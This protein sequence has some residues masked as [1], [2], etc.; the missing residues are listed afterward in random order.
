MDPLSD[1]I[2]ASVAEQTADSVLVTDRDGVIEYV[3]PSFE[4]LTGYAKNE[5]VGQ[6]PSLLK[7]GLHDQEFYGLLW[8]TI[9]A[10]KCYKDVLINRKKNG[11]FYYTEKTI[12]PIRENGE[13]THFVSTDRDVTEVRKK[14]EELERYAKELER[15]NNDLQQFAY[16][17][18]HDLQEPVRTVVSFLQLLK[19]KLGEIPPEAEELLQH[20]IDGGKRMQEMINALLNFS[21]AGRKT[22]FVDVSLE[23]VLAE[24]VSDLDLNL[25][26][27]HASVTHDPLP[28]VTGNRVQLAQVL[29]NLIA[30]AVKYRSDAAPRIH[31]GVD[32]SP[33]DWII[34]VSDNGIGIEPQNLEKVFEL[35]SRF[36][37][38]KH[39]A[40]SG[41]GLAFC[42]RVVT[43]HGGKIWVE[44]TPGAGSTF[45]FSLP[46][47]K[48]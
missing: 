28:H 35:F 33:R 4:S 21:R 11:D 44:S 2:L 14:Q 24:V 32:S 23:Q 42:H 7:S 31:V 9:L 40:G 8:K 48:E 3:N 16:F 26:E 25:R 12:T 45:F 15:S 6:K 36:S 37:T 43:R 47:K 46:R 41:I 22:E 19:M 13:V 38:E 5:V 18:S 39:R 1:E 29:Q 27:N 20:A 34:S 30:N 10:G 17:A